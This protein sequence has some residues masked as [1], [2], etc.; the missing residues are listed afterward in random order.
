MANFNY[1][2][3]EYEEKV[4]TLIPEG[5]YRVRIEDA[6]EK[7]SKAG[8]AMF[9]LTLTVPG[10][11][12]KLWYYLVLFNDDTKRT[13]QNLGTFFN[14]FDIP[15]QNRVIKDGVER[16]WIGKVGAVRVKH[17]QYNGENQAKVAYL[18]TGKQKA[19][20]PPWAESN[21]SSNG[22]NAFAELEVTDEEFPF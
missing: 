21:A 12:S 9:E 20:L 16:T 5:N 15:E 1:N 8:N 13:N 3:N 14:S 10:H 18:L 17:E 22:D 7:H 4:F 2:P 19:D 6:V 11:A